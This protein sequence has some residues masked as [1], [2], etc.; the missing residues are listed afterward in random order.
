MKFQY[1]YAH[2]TDSALNVVL[3]E[4]KRLS[5][6]AN[7]NSQIKGCKHHEKLEGR[8]NTKTMTKC[9]NDFMVKCFS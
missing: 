5:H 1:Y 6:K 7:F 8:I 9:S 4:G 3:R 2:R